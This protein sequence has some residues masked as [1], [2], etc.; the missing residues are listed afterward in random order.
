MDSLFLRHI[1]TG[2]L[3]AILGGFGASDA[4]EKVDFNRDVRPI[5]AEK[6]YHCHGPDEATRQADLRLDHRDAVEASGV[7]VA[8]EPAESPLIERI[9][10]T[11]PDERM[12]PPDAKIELDDAQRQILREWVLQGAPWAEHWSFATLQQPPLPAEETDSTTAWVRNPIDRF[13]FPR[14]RDE[15]LVPA[16]PATRERLLR[17]AALDLTGLPP[18]PE[19]VATFLEDPSPLAYER[20]IDRLLATPAYGERMAWDW[21]DAARYADTNG[22]QGDP[23]RTMWPWRDWVVDSINANLPFDQFTRQQIAGDLLDQKTLATQIATGFNRNNMHNGE[24][25]RIAEESRVENVMDRAETVAT[26][27]LGL[28]LTCCRC[29]DHKYDPLSIEDYYRFY[30]FFNNTSENGAGRSGQMAPT[31]MFRTGEDRV[32]ESQLQEERALAREKVRA[33]EAN[34]AIEDSGTDDADEAV[35]EI[36]KILEAKVEERNGEQLKKLADYFASRRGDYAASLSA[37]QQAAEAHNR[38]VAGLPK[39]MVMDTRKEQRPTFILTGGAYD[40]RGE[41]VTADVPQSLPSLP[42]H[43]PN[44]R[45]GLADWLLAEE[46]PLTARVI[47]NRYWQIFFGRGLVSTPEDFGTQGQRPTHPELLDWLAAEFRRSEWDVKR[48]HRMIVTSATYRQS[49]RMSPTHR[50]TDPENRLLARGPRH[51]MP[52]WM[53]RDQ[54]LAA[55]GLLVDRA[56]GPSVKPYQPENIW[57]EATFGKKK[58]VPDTGEK[59][60]RRSL[61]TYWRRIVGP[62]MFFDTSRRQTCHVTGTVTNTPLHALTT[63]NDVTFVEAARRLA[64]RALREKPDDPEGQLTFAFQLATAREPTEQ[65]AA[66]LADR[67][68]A[69]NQMF[70]AAPD[71]ALELISVG[72]SPHDPSLDPVTHAACTAMCSLILN[73]DETLT[74]E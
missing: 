37:L 54:A 35:Q 71:D 8:G 45:R 27:W 50:E 69:V 31:V 53:L 65:E 42:E 60:Y 39:V 40:K 33:H 52:S 62:T 73:L 29:H 23:E 1:A 16:A 58:Y 63:L 48:L 10:S 28:T 43:A 47:V 25:G 19:Q 56:G 51:R 55:S 22:Y 6:C 74:K 24:G 41:S 64:E 20:A 5:L 44:D 7:V 26:V 66:L 49:S 18:A 38:F 9:L 11:D 2:C 13:I 61:Y 15:G 67:Y 34:L 4:A 17:R 30:A 72:A 12:P 21:L 46:N 32:R 14:I 36:K 68:R 59:L 3:A 57:R 70:A